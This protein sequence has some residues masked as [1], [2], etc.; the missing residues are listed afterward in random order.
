[1]YDERR[2]TRIDTNLLNLLSVWHEVPWLIEIWRKEREDNKKMFDFL[3]RLKA[4]HRAVDG[5]LVFEN[6][7]L[8]DDQLEKDILQYLRDR[9][10]G[11][12]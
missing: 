1:M 12:G 5:T 4:Y 9:E 3:E 8:L 11:E 10:E 2:K 7:L 6:Y